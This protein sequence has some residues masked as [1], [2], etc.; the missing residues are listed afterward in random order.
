MALDKVWNWTL[1]PGGGGA[2]VSPIWQ[3]NFVYG[4]KCM[5][6]KH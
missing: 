2:G 4:E 3:L 1:W 5:P 6:G